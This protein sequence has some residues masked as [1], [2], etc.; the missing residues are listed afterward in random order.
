MSFCFKN[1]DLL[2]PFRNNFFSLKLNDCYMPNTLSCWLTPNL[3]LKI[4]AYVFT[5]HIVISTANV[6]SIKILQGWYTTLIFH[7]AFF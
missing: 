5:E 7:I 6:F 1:L 3:A 2:D 4:A